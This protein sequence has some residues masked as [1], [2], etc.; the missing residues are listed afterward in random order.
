M[1]N[2]ALSTTMPADERAE[3][4]AYLLRRTRALL[5]TYDGLAPWPRYTDVEWVARS[6][7]CTTRQAERLTAEVRATR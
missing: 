2:P 3:R 1:N 4:H 6:L 5:R 7:D